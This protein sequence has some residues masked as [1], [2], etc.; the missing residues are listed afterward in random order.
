MRSHHFLVFVV[1]VVRSPS[2]NDLWGMSFWNDVWASA[3]R[4][5]GQVGRAFDEI[6]HEACLA[7]SEC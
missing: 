7:D 1:R 3:C 2:N 6:V 5:A 4:A